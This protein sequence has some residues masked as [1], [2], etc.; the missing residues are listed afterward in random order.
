MWLLS[1][2]KELALPSFAEVPIPSIAI[3]PEPTVSLTVIDITNTVSTRNQAAVVWTKDGS[4]HL[5]LLD[6]KQALVR[7]LNVPVND[8]RQSVEINWL[9]DGTAFTYQQD[10][11]GIAVVTDLYVVRAD[12]SGEVH[13]LLKNQPYFDGCE[14]RSN[15]QYLSCHY[16][17]GHGELCEAKVFDPTTW[18]LTYD[19]L[20]ACPWDQKTPATDDTDAA[21]LQ[22]CR[23]FKDK[24]DNAY[25]TSKVSPNRDYV[26]LT[27]R[28]E[29]PIKDEL[30][31]LEVER[32]Q[33]WRVG[34]VNNWQ[35][36]FRQWS[37]SADGRYLAWIEEDQIRVF[38]TAT[39]AI[40][41]YFI[42]DAKMLNVAW[43]PLQ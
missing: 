37:W 34:R 36:T 26:A 32:R 43:S 6:F 17:S 1:G 9:A 4:R 3:T 11:Y 35:S 28:V 25:C 16:V 10:S 22:F 20:S 42:P 27:T 41:A 8:E 5:G 31:V 40:T 33:V 39:H 24:Y 38:D 13:A 21:A 7:Q 29:S 12:D 30:V 14:W 19:G 2:C 18:R 15:E 23:R